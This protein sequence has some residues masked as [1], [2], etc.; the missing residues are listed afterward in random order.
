VPRSGERRGPPFRMP[1]RCPACGARLRTDG[2]FERCPAGLS[3][4]AQLVGR[5]I[6]FGSRDAL[7]IAGLGQETAQRLVEGGLVKSVAD[8][9][10]LRESDLVRLDRFA[11]LSAKNLVS[12]IARAKRVDLARFLYAIGIPEV[13]KSTGRDL[14]E[15]FADLDA[16][17][18]ATDERLMDVA[19]VGPAVAG[20]IVAFFRER[21][22]RAVIDACRARGVVLRAARAPSIGRLDGKRIAFTGTLA[23]MPRAEA[24]KRVRDLGGKPS[25]TVGANTDFVVVGAHPGSKLTR[26]RRLGIPLLIE[27]QFRALTRPTEMQHG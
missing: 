15:H 1:L 22:N 18:S 27:R 3:C 7:D 10:T 14:A 20:A 9:F 8:L 21:R 24:E 25:S 2:P 5:V 6:H 26:A 16:V 4:P 23:S 11:A 13:G 17:A 19:G 12:G